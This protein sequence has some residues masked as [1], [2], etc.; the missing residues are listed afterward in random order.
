MFA[1]RKLRERK[2]SKLT[3]GAA[4][5]RSISPNA[6]RPRIASANRVMIRA[7]PQPHALPSTS[8]STSEVRPIVSAAMPG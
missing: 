5:R 4:E 6:A 2:K 8:A 7:L 3:I 1:P